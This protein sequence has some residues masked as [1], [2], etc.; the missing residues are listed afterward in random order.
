MRAHWRVLDTL[1]RDV[2]RDAGEMGRDSGHSAAA[3]APVSA[4]LRGRSG[5]KEPEVLGVG[6]VTPRT[7]WAGA[8]RQEGSAGVRAP[9]TVRV[10]RHSRVGRSGVARK[11]GDSWR[12]SRLMQRLAKPTVTGMARSMPLSDEV[13]EGF[14]ISEF[15]LEELPRRDPPGKFYVHGRN[16]IARSTPA[17]TLVVFHHHGLVVAH[18]RLQTNWWRHNDDLAG[19]PN[20][21]CVYLLE[22]A[23]VLE[24]GLAFHDLPATWQREWGRRRFDMCSRK[25][26]AA[27]QE[28]FLKTCG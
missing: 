14:P 21:I 1:F 10:D 3:L 17:G 5:W 20:A 27:A 6:G 24:P 15:F 9:A 4:R 13:L 8:H 2:L 26:D 16:Y 28:E 22:R 23:A 7:R 19:R 25:L 11:R 12:P 18:A